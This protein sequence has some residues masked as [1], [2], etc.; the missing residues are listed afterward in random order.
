MHIYRFKIMFE[1]HGDFLR[2][3]EVRSDQTFEAFFIAFA[4]NLKL[5]PATLSS[6]FI[7]DHKFRKKHEISLVDMDPES[8]NEG[9]KAVGLMKH[10]QLNDFIDDPH[11]KLL[12]VYDYLHYWTFYI[13]LLRILPANPQHVYPR[14]FKSEGETPRE[15]LA[16]PVDI[17]PGVDT[18]LDF[19]FEQDEGY[20]PEDLEGLEDGEGLPGD[21]LN[22]AEGFEDE[23]PE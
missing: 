19:A 18:S 11:Q 13:E 12:L 22:N 9:H 20:D 2:E 15:L 5:D 1:D 10:S 8:G 7:C 6:F 17:L 4:E 3:V 16:T 21:D 14:F 23:K